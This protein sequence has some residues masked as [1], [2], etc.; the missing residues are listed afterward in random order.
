MITLTVIKGWWSRYWNSF[1]F[2]GLVFAALFFAAS[3]T[4]SLLP[5][6]IVAQGLLSG[7]ALAVGYGIGILTVWLW[8]FLE[9]PH[10]GQ[11][12]EIFSKRI[13]AAGTA[14]V[15]VGFLRQMTFWQN[16]IRELMN[17][18]PLQSAAPYQ[19]ALL[20]LM[21]GTLLIAFARLL[22]NACHFL[23][24]K[25][26][27]FLPR[28]ASYVLG[29]VIV[30]FLFMQ[31]VNGVLARSLLN[32]SDRSFLQ[33]DALIDEGVQQPTLTTASGS[34]ESLI[35]WDS[36]GR[37]GK[38]FVVSGPTQ[39]EIHEFT[40]RPSLQPLRVYVGLR[41]RATMRER[42]QLALEE[43]KRVGGFD[44]R[45]LV[46][47]N[48]T[49]TG[50]LDPSAVDTLE[51]LHGGDTAIVSMQY[52]YLP[53]WLTIT[54]DP[55]Q[56]RISARTLFDE[57]YDYWK[58]L[59]KDN[60]PRLYL[61]GLSLGALGSESC[62]DL[63][64]IFEDPIHGAVWSGPPFPSPQ[65]S[66]LTRERNEG[67]EFWL[68]KFRDGT[69]VRFTGQENSLDDGKRWGPIRSVYLQYASDPMVFFSTD[70]PFH[71][72]DWLKGKRGPDVSPHL[73]WYPIVTSLQIA[74]DLPMATSVPMGYGHNYAPE[75]YINA[76][77]AV[78]APED[79][80]NNDTPR[81]KEL[82]SGRIPESF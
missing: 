73:T 38:N 17:M 13:S 47:A 24:E 66:M 72:P 10:P 42:A 55:D 59:P 18:P 61:H 32:V 8:Q 25:I 36:I 62:A 21:F 75:H 67:T 70:L 27:R 15:F 46:V 60:R 78:T 5:R 3:V 69:M 41:S 68:P 20:A 45:V 64:T 26:N 82:F 74:F 77:L 37:R 19:T 40:G 39:R 30:A 22:L 7:F 43:L 56:S 4:P 51:Y 1:S 9:L 29:T 81:L 14:V 12:L 6:T 52:S 53:S 28:R 76:W 34:D 50:W 79:W 11:R 80:N 48:P 49:G 35:A 54:V 63:F 71:K 16:S 23:A 33:I 31:I 2:V 58:T 65:W 57:I 44:R